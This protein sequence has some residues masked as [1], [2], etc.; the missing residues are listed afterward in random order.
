M[1]GRARVRTLLSAVGM[2]ED[3]LLDSA[4][5]CINGRTSVT[6]NGH[7]GVVELSCERIRMK[8]GCGI[9]AIAGSSLA[10]RELSPDRA[11]VT[12]E[13]IDGVSY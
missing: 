9:L 2:P 5:V 13:R 11:I 8:T 7:H 12:G 4:Q 3:A 10:L 6:I 1:R